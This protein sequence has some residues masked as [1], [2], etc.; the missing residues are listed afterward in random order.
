MINDSIYGGAFMDE[1]LTRRYSDRGL[2]SMAN[3][4]PNT[5]GS[6]FFIWLEDDHGG[7]IDMDVV[8]VGQIVEGV[9]VAVRLGTFGSADGMPTRK[10]VIADCGQI[11]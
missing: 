6:M 10:V 7:D 4:G 9:D 11:S 8:V 5:N 1:S 3:R 2:V